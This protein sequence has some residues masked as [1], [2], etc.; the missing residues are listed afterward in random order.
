MDAFLIFL[1]VIVIVLLVLGPGPAMAVAAGY[2]I[3]HTSNKRSGLDSTPMPATPRPAPMPATGSATTAVSKIAP[4]PIV[5]DLRKRRKISDI[6]KGDNQL[7]I[8]LDDEFQIDSPETG[9]RTPSLAPEMVS[10]AVAKASLET[11]QGRID[12]INKKPTTT[13]TPFDVIYQN[14]FGKKVTKTGDQR[15]AEAGKFRAQLS[16]K[17]DRA[18][19]NF[20]SRSNRELFRNELEH[21]AKVEWWGEDDPD[22]EL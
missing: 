16:A 4:K 6:T 12:A 5:T 7:Q 14:E 18:R 21:F 1:V 20:T 22:Q 2:T 13:D 10:D 3:L 15:I 17:A 19:H 9:S 8:N 11:K